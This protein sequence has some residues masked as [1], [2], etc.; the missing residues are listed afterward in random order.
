MP[1]IRHF[2]FATYLLVLLSLL[3]FT[4]AAGNPG[5]MLLSVVATALSWWLVE[6]GPSRPA[7]RWL[8]NTAVLALALFLFQKLAL[9]EALRRSPGLLLW[10][11][12]FMLGLIL[13]KL[14]ERKTNRD[15]GQIMILSL[16]LMMAGAILT[17]S[18]L[19]ALCLVLYLALGI[20]VSLA[21]HLVCE[22]RRALPQPAQAVQ[23]LNAAGRRHG[24]ER[25]LRRISAGVAGFLFVFAALVFVLFPRDSA[26]GVLAHWPGRTGPTTTGFATH[27]V[28]GEPGRLHPSN[29]IVGEVQ[30][31]KNGHNIGSSSWQPY[32]QGTTLDRYDPVTAEWR[33]S[34]HDFGQTFHLP[35]TSTVTLAPRS[36]YQP[37][38]VITEYFTLNHRQGATLFLIAPA[39]SITCPGAEWVV[40]QADGSIQCRLPDESPVHYIV[41][42]ARIYRP[43]LIGPPHPAVYPGVRAWGGGLFNW[44]LAP[45]V[46]AR[47]AAL[48]KTIA[49]KLLRIPR[50]PANVSRIDLALARRFQDYLRRHY[51][52]SLDMTPVN[53]HIDPTED[54]LFNKRKLGGYCEYFSSAMIMFCRSVGIPARM[55]TGYHGGDYNPIGGYYVIRQKFAHAWVQAYIPGRGWMRFDPSPDSSLTS[56]ETPA[57]WYSGILDLG[58]WI[59]LFWLQNIIAFNRAMRTK[60]LH[61]LAVDARVFLRNLGRAPGALWRNAR[62]WL[63][64][65]SGTLAHWLAWV[66]AGLLAAAALL[67]AWLLRRRRRLERSLVAPLLRGRNRHQRRQLVRDLAF[68]DQL[69]QRLQRHGPQR[70]PHQTPWEYLQALANDP[71]AS[72]AV[73]ALRPHAEELVHIFYDIR[74]GGRP[75]TP[76]TR[77]RIQQ[78]WAALSRSRR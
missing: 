31:F 43:G 76:Q 26:E 44:M 57:T 37:G 2:N 23:A 63:F 75:V 33:R 22:T 14:F 45:P 67:T 74:F 71:A 34:E 64:T 25:D 41:K 5:L 50:T 49:R 38:S 7:P 48:A 12:Y 17:A 51:P 4:W 15:Y 6:T 78:A 61:P 39:V 8:I 47:V 73:A 69:M 59:H 42:S 77:A 40:R 9:G 18:L 54:F 62:A 10:L 56:V 13:C 20:Y 1:F 3:G 35:K 66:A 24:L 68:V 36:M 58:Q 60:L 72:D 19:F 30:I 70:Q 29:A 55:V 53:S 65:G 21:F 27:V 11:G 32:F 46:P 16:L 52:Y 28:L